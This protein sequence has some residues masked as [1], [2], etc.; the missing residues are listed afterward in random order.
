MSGQPCAVW[1]RVTIVPLIV[2]GILGPGLS[3]VPPAA[4]AGH[5]VC[6]QTLGPGSR[7][8]LDSDVGPCSNNPILTV[9]GPTTVDLNGFKVISTPPPGGPYPSRSA[10]VVGGR[11]AILL[12][13][14]VH[15][16]G[17]GV[18]LMGSGNHIVLRVTA[19]G[20]KP[21]PSGGFF[22]KSS[23]N[24]LI[25]NT[26]FNQ[27]A[28]GFLLYEPNVQLTKNRLIMNVAQGNSIGIILGTGALGNLII[29]NTA[30]NNSS[31]D[32]EDENPNCDNNRWIGNTFLTRNQGCIQ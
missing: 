30:V 13:G 23:N 8:V 2:T 11:S 14:T 28:A 20:M 19:E 10:L 12:N 26:A 3:R 25:G 4:E 9:I 15:T 7:F 22:V 1:K 17:A 31:V 18:V 16:W 24:W 6:G 21:A 32:L 29:R 27:L 5:I